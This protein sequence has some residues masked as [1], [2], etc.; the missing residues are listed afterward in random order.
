M[1]LNEL[2]IKIQISSEEL[3]QTIHTSCNNLFGPPISHILQ[4]DEYYDTPDGQ[5][6][7]QDLVI[8]IR[9]YGKKQTIAL[10]SPRVELSSGITNRIEL[11]FISAEGEKVHEQ[12][13]N[14]GLNPNEAAEKE[15]WTFIYNDCEIVL[16]KLP[17]IGFFIEIEGSSEDTINDTVSLLNLS[18]CKVVRQNYGELMMAKFRELKLPLSN[19]RATFA[20]EMECKCNVV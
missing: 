17:F 5:L 11:E 14:Q 4:L 18:S 7:K 12:L 6:K 15:R 20:Y 8:R 13:L 9:S 1:K 19:M 16:D 10:K 2:E 3:F